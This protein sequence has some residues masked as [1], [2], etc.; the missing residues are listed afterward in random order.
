MTFATPFAFALFVTAIPIVIFYILKIRLRRVPV[1]TNLFWKQIFDEKPPRSIW[2][3]LRHLL[4]LRFPAVNAQGTTWTLRVAGS[5]PARR[6]PPGGS[7]AAEQQATSPP[8][9]SPLL[10]SSL[11]SSEEAGPHKPACEGSTPS[12]ATNIPESSNGRTR[13]FDPRDEGST[14]SSG[15][16]NIWVWLNLARALG[17]EPR[18]C[19]F[20]SRHPDHAGLVIW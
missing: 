17:L 6:A 20:E 1:S 11:R 15:A 8:S 9:L 12:A 13:G 18:D 4:S 3:Y 5:T 2:Q 16:D 10:F 7:S 14:P 19:E